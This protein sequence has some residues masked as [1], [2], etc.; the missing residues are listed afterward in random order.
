VSQSDRYVRIVVTNWSN[1]LAAT[2]DAQL[3]LLELS[4]L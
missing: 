4:F 1:K 3:A 2:P